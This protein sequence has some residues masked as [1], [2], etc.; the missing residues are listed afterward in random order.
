MLKKKE[1]EGEDQ[2]QD[3]SFTQS[4]DTGNKN[5]LESMEKQQNHL[6]HALIEEEQKVTVSRNQI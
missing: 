2:D 5:L 1:E 6:T 4:K 3:G